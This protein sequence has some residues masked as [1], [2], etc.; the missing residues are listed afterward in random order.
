MRQ[1]YAEVLERL[2]ISLIEED[3]EHQQQRTTAVLTNQEDASVWP[4]WPWPPWG[5]DDDGDKPVNKTLEAHDLA[6]GVVI[7]ERKLAQASLD[8]CVTVTKVQVLSWPFIYTTRD[9]LQQDPI[10]TYNPVP[11]SN[12]TDTVTQIHF[13]AYFSTF[14]PRNYPDRIIMTY[15]EYAVSLADILNETSSKVVEAYLVTRAALALSPFLG[16]DTEAWQAQRSLHEVLSGI[17][18]GAVGDRAEYCIGQTENALGFA[19][20]KYFVNETFGGDSRKKG[21]KVITG[22]AFCNDKY[23]FYVISHCLHRHRGQFQGFTRP[24]RLDGQG[25]SWSCCTEGMIA[26]TSPGLETDPSYQAD[27][28]RIKVGYPTS[29]DTLNPRSILNYYNLV[30]TDKQDFLGN[31]L[32]ASYVYFWHSLFVLC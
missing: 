28:I 17:K 23:A 20:G 1:I 32:S 10:A 11:V 4:P 14:T 12:L 16:M 2:L 26:I 29:P 27:A 6:Q 9:V 22:R 19:A 7:F 15:P 31:V 25:I 5:G 13:P 3:T 30:K 21:T 8:L 18:K 24:H